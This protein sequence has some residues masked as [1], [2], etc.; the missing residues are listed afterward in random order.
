MPRFVWH[1][2]YAGK[3]VAQVEEEIAADLTHDQRA[4]A[5]AHDAAEQRENDA[6]A[7][8]LALEKK[9]GVFDMGWAEADPKELAGRITAFEL[10]RENAQRLF[11]YA[12]YR[13]AQGEAA[14]PPR[15]RPPKK[16]PA[17]GGAR[18][19]GDRR[20]AWRCARTPPGIESGAR[21]P[22]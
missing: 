13:A 7:S 19:S 2:E 17:P 16:I 8:T 1:P 14:A 12:E 3:R 20:R 11:P 9:W 18:S 4:L 6:L 5:M 10:A 15:P 22:Q 21:T